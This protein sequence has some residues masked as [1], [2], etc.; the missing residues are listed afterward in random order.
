[1][2][3]VPTPKTKCKPKSKD[4]EGGSRG[5][6]GLSRLS[7]A[8]MLIRAARVGGQF[9]SRWGRFITVVIAQ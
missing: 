9:I 4:L 6:T 8:Q 2:Q 1:M 5:K 7:A 3:Y